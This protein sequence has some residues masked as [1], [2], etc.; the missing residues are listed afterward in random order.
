MIVLS[1]ISMVASRAGV[2][3][4]EEDVLV[5]CILSTPSHY[6]MSKPVSAEQYMQKKR[7]DSL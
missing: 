4:M 3:I 7:T 2:Q 1:K 6:I 5:D